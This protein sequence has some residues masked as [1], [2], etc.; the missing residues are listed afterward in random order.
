MSDQLVAEA[1]V[2][3]T[4]SEHK[5]QTSIPP[6]VFELAIPAIGLL[7]YALDRTATGVSLRCTLSLIYLNL[8][9]YEYVPANIYVWE[10]F[11]NFLQ[12]KLLL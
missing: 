2:Y 10:H 5:R 11:V 9:T 4:H 12:S 8:N 1:A 3:T 7:T 6:A